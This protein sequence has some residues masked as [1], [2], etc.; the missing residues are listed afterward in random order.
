MKNK[1]LKHIGLTAGII[2][3]GW[4]SASCNFQTEKLKSTGS[5]RCRRFLHNPPF[6]CAVYG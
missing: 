5:F 4:M 6:F 3:M 2:A 1:I